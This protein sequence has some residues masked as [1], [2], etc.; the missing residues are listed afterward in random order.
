MISK[1][2]TVALIACAANYEGVLFENRYGG[3]IGHA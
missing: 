2:S 1:G 3:L